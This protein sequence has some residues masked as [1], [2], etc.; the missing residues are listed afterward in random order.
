MRKQK[1]IHP[2]PDG[3]TKRIHSSSTEGPIKDER[4][5]TKRTV[6]TNKPPAVFGAQ[7]PVVST[8]II[9][10]RK[11]FITMG[12]IRPLTGGTFPFQMA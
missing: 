4:L 6:Y 8:W 9:P 5:S 1:H 7:K 3:S 12:S 11:W 10:V 2:A